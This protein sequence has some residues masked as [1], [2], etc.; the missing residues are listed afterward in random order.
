[1]RECIA[2]RLTTDCYALGHTQ[3][4]ALE[5]REAVTTNYDCLFE[6]AVLSGRA[7]GSSEF[8]ILPYSPVTSAGQWLLKLH[9]CIE[10]GVEDIVFSARI[11]CATQTTEA[12]CMGSSRQC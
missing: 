7:A 9:G 4:A 5:A 6:K 10:K 11:I 1:M 12:L 8:S 2:E 3:L